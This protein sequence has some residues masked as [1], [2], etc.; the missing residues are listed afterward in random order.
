MGRDY[1]ATLRNLTPSSNLVE[2]I[3]LKSMAGLNLNFDSASVSTSSASFVPTRF[4]IRR[5]P[6]SRCPAG[7]HGISQEDKNQNA[8][9]VASEGK[10][11]DQETKDGE[12]GKRDS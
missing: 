11:E 2:V 12:T 5:L 8:N 10:R 3:D 6:S 4:H 7:S 1:G 9:A